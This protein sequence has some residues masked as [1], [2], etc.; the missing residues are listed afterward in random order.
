MRGMN[1]HCISFMSHIFGQEQRH[2]LDWH[3]L[4]FTY[5]LSVHPIYDPKI[6]AIIWIGIFGQRMVQNQAELLSFRHRFYRHTILNFWLEGQKL[7]V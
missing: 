3:L 2:H 7:A 6:N 4:N 1:V 5:I